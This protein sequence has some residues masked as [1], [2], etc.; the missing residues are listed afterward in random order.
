MARQVAANRV[1]RRCN[2][3]TQRPLSL[4][5]RDPSGHRFRCPQRRNRS[6][7]SI[8]AFDLSYR[9]GTKRSQDD[10]AAVES[11]RNVRPDKDA[12]SLTTAP[13]VGTCKRERCFMPKRLEKSFSLKR[14]RSNDD[15]EW[16]ETRASLRS[17][18]W[19][20]MST[21]RLGWLIAELMTVGGLGSARCS[22][23]RSNETARPG[24]EQYRQYDSVTLKDAKVSPVRF[25]LTTNGLKGRC[26]TG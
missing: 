1:C 5:R 6:G 18:D 13:V 19:P 2:S 7:R 20:D 8:R 23:R 16:S 15:S 11:L 25:E 12:V 14:P 3:T 21:A 26:S 22:R 4:D 9:Q 10:A 17:A 24:P